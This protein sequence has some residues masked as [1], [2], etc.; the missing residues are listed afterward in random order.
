[1]T[2]RRRWRER[3]Q[4]PAGQRPARAAF[5]APDGAR[6]IPLGTTESLVEGKDVVVLEHVRD[7][8]RQRA[9][10]PEHSLPRLGGGLEALGDQDD[11]MSR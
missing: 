4:L 8:G 5:E 7:R 1:M 6:S 9:G 2:W 3:L 10:G 11:G